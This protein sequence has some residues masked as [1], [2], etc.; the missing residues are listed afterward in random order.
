M[1]NEAKKDQ[2]DF[3]N[4]EYAQIF[5]K[6]QIKIKKNKLNISEKNIKKMEVELDGLQ[7]KM[8][9]SKDHIKHLLQLEKDEKI[10]ND[11]KEYVNK[12]DEKIEEYNEKLNKLDILS[13]RNK[14]LKNTFIREKQNFH[15]KLKDG[16]ELKMKKLKAFEGLIDMLSEKFNLSDNDFNDLG[17]DS[18]DDLGDCLLYTSDAA[19]DP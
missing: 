4:C 11:M 10:E 18:N 2:I 13:L 7:K 5:L 6:E 19:D 15:K 14:N 12:L 3:I 8:K 16:K 17:D 9:S 1:Y